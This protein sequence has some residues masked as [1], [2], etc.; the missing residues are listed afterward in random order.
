MSW[1]SRR[2]NDATEAAGNGLSW[3]YNKAISGVGTA[4]AFPVLWAGGA[5][6]NSIMDRIGQ[7]GEVVECGI[8]TGDPWTVVEGTSTAFDAA[9]A[10]V[11]NRVV[12]AEARFLAHILPYS[13]LDNRY[14]GLVDSVFNDARTKDPDGYRL[15]M[16]KGAMEIPG[17]VIASSVPYMVDLAHTIPKSVGIKFYSGSFGGA[18]QEISNRPLH[19]VTEFLGFDFRHNVSDSQEM[20]AMTTSLLPGL[21]MGGAGLAPLKWAGQVGKHGNTAATTLKAAA[22]VGGAIEL[23][24]LAGYGVQ[25][26]PIT[27]T[28]TTEAKNENEAEAGAEVEAPTP[29]VRTSQQSSNGGTTP[30]FNQR[31]QEP[32]KPEGNEILNFLK[33]TWMGRAVGTLVALFGVNAFAPES[34]KGI[35]TLAALTIGAVIVM[36][37][38]D[39]KAPKNEQK[40]A[41]LVGMT[42]E[43]G[44]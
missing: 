38:P 35:G 16:V 28:A 14:I 27:H 36:Q 42:P 30:V 15:A 10:P 2:W 26:P 17:T 21:M 24:K 5:E 29:E 20:V 34:M 7:A 18:V 43:L 23:T 37:S 22:A 3:T 9:A 31:S 19:N 6:N 8:K 32:T 13:A 44:I 4:L 1:L 41:N 12:D 39:L 25:K 33:D 11:Y 40:Q